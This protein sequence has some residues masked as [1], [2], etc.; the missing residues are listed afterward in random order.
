[1]LITKEELS[2]LLRTVMYLRIDTSFA[3]LNQKQVHHVECYR[4]AAFVPKVT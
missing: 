4:V 2:Y 3:K 1:M